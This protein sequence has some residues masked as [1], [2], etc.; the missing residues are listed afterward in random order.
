MRVTRADVAKRA[1][2]STATVSYALNQSKPL[3]KETVERVLR[4]AQELHYLPD[5]IARSMSTKESM[6]IGVLVEDI[7]NPLF[8]DIILGFE[9]MAHQYGYFVSVCTS[10]SRYDAY[11]EDA[12][13]RRLDG[14]FVMALPTN[15]DVDRMYGLTEY[16]I[17]V[18]TSGY[19][20]ADVKRICSIENDV[21]TAMREAMLHLY[22]RGHR[23][24]AF[25]TGLSRK[26]IFDAR[27]PGYLQMV[28]KLGLPYGDDLLI[29]GGPPYGTTMQDGYEL[30]RRLLR[31]RKKCTAIICVND[32][33]AMG[34]YSALR[35]AG[36]RIPEDVAVVGFDGIPFTQFCDPPLTT[37]CI[38]QHAFGQKAFKLL[39]AHMTQGVTGFYSNH[40]EL[41]A[42]RST[43]FRR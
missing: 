36:L 30:T 18:I 40:L 27:V 33:T 17:G 23:E 13:A 29:E 3:P 43:E 9:S 14:V 8:G 2:V 28:E 10:H 16:G 5:A 20:N 11:F 19:C 21:V 7:S 41:I 32:L 39:H 34:A 22:D 42:R 37:L 25:V 38:N 4:A 12:V 26:L 6:Q 24:I 1:G 35:E 15:Y 31:S